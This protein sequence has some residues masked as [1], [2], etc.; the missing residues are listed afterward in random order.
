MNQGRGDRRHAGYAAFVIHRLSGVLL[1]L[2]LPLHFLALGL[3]LEGARALD[4]F[5]VFA[6][7][8][9][10]KVSEW[11]LVVLLSVHLTFGLR[12]LVLEFLPWRGVRKGW[13][14]WGAGVAVAAGLLFIIGVR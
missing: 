13:I 12:V 8:P 10:V 11:G 7:L 2:F 1:A 5:L 6:E 4:E 9:W 3:A 14:G